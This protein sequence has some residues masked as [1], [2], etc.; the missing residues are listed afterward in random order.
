MDSSGAVTF[1]AMGVLTADC[2]LDMTYFPYDTQECLFTFS[3]S[4]STVR[5]VTIIAGNVGFFRD[6]FI[7]NA[8]WDV[9]AI[10]SEVKH[11]GFPNTFAALWMTIKLE[12]RPDYYI[13]NIF[14]PVTLLSVLGLLQLSVPLVGGERLSYGLAV[15][16]SLSVYG[17]VIQTTIPKS[18]LT[19]P[20]VVQYSL[21]IFIINSSGILMSLALTSLRNGQIVHKPGKKIFHVFGIPIALKVETEGKSCYADDKT[22]TCNDSCN[23]KTNAQTEEIDPDLKQLINRVSLL[24]F[25]INV[26]AFAMIS[27]YSLIVVSLGF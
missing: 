11:V 7:P 24:C 6:N 16:L 2:A 10:V 23:S 17:T 8:E 1:G 26:L 3:M 4:E 18:S 9:V 21:G 14:V 22:D 19:T 20:I 27:L 12:R 25:L 15:L 13:I 5:E